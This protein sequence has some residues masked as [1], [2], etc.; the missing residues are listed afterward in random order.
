M[1]INVNARWIEKGR[2]VEQVIE[3]LGDKFIERGG[4]TI[5][6]YNHYGLESNYSPLI[7]TEDQRGLVWLD[8]NGYIT[9]FLD[10]DEILFT[11][12]DTCTDSGKL[13]ASGFT[14]L[15]KRLLD[16]I[17]KAVIHG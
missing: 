15:E 6:Y 17:D 8:K 7:L 4:N 10:Y 14:E 12:S 13:V 9:D 16:I 1:L 5:K 11:E 3:M 2:E